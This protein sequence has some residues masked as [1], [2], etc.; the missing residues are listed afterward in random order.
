[1]ADP[2]PTGAT[3]LGSGLGRDAALATRGER[4]RGSGWLA[5]EE[6]G[7]D[8]Y[9]R[10]YEML[11]R[12]RHSFEYTLRLNTPGQ[13]VLPPSRVEAM[14]APDRFGEVPNAA[15]EVVP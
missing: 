1:V 8:V 2:V 11:P 4:N 14:Y 6:R 3:L 10:Y 13:F 12:G 15:L 9:R 7:F 5:F